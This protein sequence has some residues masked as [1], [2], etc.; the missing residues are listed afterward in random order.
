[1]NL[2]VGTTGRRGGGCSCKRWAPWES[3]PLSWLLRHRLGWDPPGWQSVTCTGLAL[4]PAGTLSS[5]QDPWDNLALAETDIS[6]TAAGRQ[7][8]VWRHAGQSCVRECAETS[9]SAQTLTPGSLY[10]CT[11]VNVQKLDCSSTA[12]KLKG[13]GTLW[14]W[15]RFCLWAINYIHVYGCDARKATHDYIRLCGRGPK[16]AIKAAQTSCVEVL[17]ATSGRHH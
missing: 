7:R 14:S 9:S 2:R 13:N 8:R 6:C 17:D 3:I 16:T 15:N 10:Q 1:M 4:C 12:R 11:D 5:T